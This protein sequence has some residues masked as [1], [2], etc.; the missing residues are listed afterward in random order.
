M[1]MPK[2]SRSTGKKIL[3]VNVFIDETVP[4]CNRCYVFSGRHLKTNEIGWYAFCKKTG[5]MDKVGPYETFHKALK[6]LTLI[7]GCDS[8][9]FN[10]DDSKTSYLPLL[11]EKIQEEMKET[12]GK[13]H[14]EFVMGPLEYF[15]K[16]RDYLD[17]NFK[18][19]FKIRLF[20]A[21]PDDCMAVVQAVKPCNNSEDF[22]LKI[23][24]FAGIIDRMNINDMQGIIKD[25]KKRKEQ[26]SIL[27]LEQ[28]LKENVH[29]Y[30]KSAIFNLRNLMTLRNKLY[31]AHANSSEILKV[32]RNLG[33]DKYPLDDW[34]KGW[35]K[36]L[37]LCSSSLVQ[38]V[39]ILQ[40]IQ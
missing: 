10:K 6:T 24:A 18:E 7:R 39:E 2:S 17:I 14:L 29:N 1:T 3:G 15:V 40:S 19:R 5:K 28:I 31:P 9:E 26:R 11:N 22:A 25:E 4:N 38:L 16:Y 21:L 35:R 13:E 27:L 33:I 34:E 20:N 8:C 30:P 32:L 12:F 23:Q 36:I 37:K